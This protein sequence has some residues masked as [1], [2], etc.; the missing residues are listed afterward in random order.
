[1]FCCVWRKHENIEYIQQ[2]YTYVISHP[3]FNDMIVTLED[4]F[5]SDKILDSRR[6]QN[7]WYVIVIL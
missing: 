3:A 4:Y 6:V 5:G 1:M 2:E 7:K